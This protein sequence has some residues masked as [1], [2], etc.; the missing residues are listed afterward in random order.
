MDIL[1]E[2]P[3]CIDAE[4]AR[5]L[6]RVA[7][8]NGGDIYVGCVLRFS[9]SLNTFKDLLRK[10][11]SLHSFRVECGSYLPDWRHT[12]D[13]RRSYSARDE[14]GGVLRDLVHEVD[15]ASWILGWPKAVYARLRNLGRLGIEAEETADLIW[16]TAG[17]CLVSMS[18]D[19]LSKPPRRRMRATGE[20]GILEWDG[21]E[22][23]VSLTTA[24]GPAG[25]KDS[26]QTR[27]EMFL[28]QDRAFI[29]LTNG[30]REPRL[31]T[32]EEGVK[33]LAICDAGRRSSHCRKEE[34][35]EYS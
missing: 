16:E 8:D 21:I 20:R 18:L 27:E 31:A 13:Y 34:P 1:V 5:R 12:S 35:V 19:Y 24:D 10:I 9:E 7:E 33:V 3:L 2:K 22:N 17:G 28:E 11:G 4:Q 15:Y 29:N 30:F 6:L 25:S 23:T 26:S 32:G 14:E